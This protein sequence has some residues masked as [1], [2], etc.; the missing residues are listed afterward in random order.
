MTRAFNLT[1]YLCPTLLILAAPTL[2]VRGASI[3]VNAAC[4]LP[5]AIIAANTDTAAGGCTAGH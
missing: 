2:R 5:N 1:P 4:S 3:T